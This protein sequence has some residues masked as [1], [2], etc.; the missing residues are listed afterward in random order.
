MKYK[1]RT[2]PNGRILV[3]REGDATA[4]FEVVQHPYGHPGAYVSDEDVAHGRLHPRVE[5]LS[6]E[7]F[8]NDAERKEA[9]ELARRLDAIGFRGGRRIEATRQQIAAARRRVE[10]RLGRVLDWDSLSQ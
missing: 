8:R 2:L 9:L 4:T 3:R 1:F 7:G 10:E 6:T 5:A